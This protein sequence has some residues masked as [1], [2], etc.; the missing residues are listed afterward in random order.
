MLSRIWAKLAARSPRWC[1][2]YVD[3]VR[4]LSGLEVGGPSE[5]FRR[6]NVAPIYPVVSA[7]DGCTFA[8]ETLWRSDIVEGTTYQFAKDKP[9][10]RQLLREATDL[11]SI[12]DGAYDFLLAS[13]VIEHVANPL[14][15]LGE[16]A[17]VVRN[18]GA[19]VLVLP[20]KDGTFDHR[21]PVTTLEHLVSDRASDVAED[22][23]THL[24]E[25][26]RLVD[27]DRAPEAKPF[28]AFRERSLRNR[29]NRGMHHHVFDT[30]LAVRMIDCAGL[31][32]VSV[33]HALPFH[34]FVLA[35]KSPTRDN[36]SVLA[37]AA[38]FIRES[39]FPS[40]RA[41]NA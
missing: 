30:R 13:H 37:P 4:G 21:R 1:D 40:D 5:I 36:E 33:N 10:G 35:R 18:G 9:K 41:P 27:L 24:D 23:T 39:P 7:L 32:I 17:R 8:S 6:R 20:H 19:M 38:S 26:L 11:A 3:A 15:A 12:A 31:Q 29:E 14:R 16:W 2:P 22:D 25:W 34:I 28:E